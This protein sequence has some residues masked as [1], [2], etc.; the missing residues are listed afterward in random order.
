MSTVFPGHRK[1]PKI[2]QDFINRGREARNLK[3]VVSSVALAAIYITGFDI[4]GPR[5]VTNGTIT[6]KGHLCGVNIVNNGC[7]PRGS[8]DKRTVGCYLGPNKGGG[9]GVF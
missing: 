8:T 2:P 4:T 1:L 6:G 7:M 5:S 9:G 3:Q